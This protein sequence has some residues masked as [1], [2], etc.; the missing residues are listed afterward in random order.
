LNQVHTISK[1]EEKKSI[2]TTSSF[3]GLLPPPYPMSA[4]NSTP[5]LQT[6]YS[7]SR[8][9]SLLSSSSSSN[10]NANTYTTDSYSATRPNSGYGM[11]TSSTS[12]YTIPTQKNFYRSNPSPVA[13]P[14]NFLHKTREKEKSELSSLNDKFADYVEKVRY[15]EAQNKKVHL[16][17]SILSDKQQS[18]CQ[19]IK[20]MFET[21]LKELKQ[22]VEKIS[23]EKQNA[24]YVAKDIQQTIPQLKQKLSQTF[25]ESDSSKYDTEKVE[26]QLSGIE[27]DVNM[28]KRRLNHQDD[29]HLRWKQLAQHI[30]RLV[31]QAKNEIQNETI[32]KTKCEQQ[33]QQLKIDMK[34]LYEQQQQ[35]INDLKLTTFGNS[36]SSNTFSNSGSERA[37]FFKSELSN[38]IRKIR[39]EYER[40]NDLQRQDLHNQF[41]LQY[42]EISK[43][44]PDIQSIFQSEHD[45]ERVRQDED[46]VRSDV[47]RV[48]HDIMN[49][50]QKNSE[51]KIRLREVQIKIDMIQDERKRMDSKQNDEL[52][53][54][55]EKQDRMS[56]EFDDVTLKQTSLEKEINT[57][58]DLL[59]GTLK[60][61]VDQITDDYQQQGNSNQNG[62]GKQRGQR[63]ASMDRNGVTNQY[64]RGPWSSNMLYGNNTNKYEIAPT[65]VAPIATTITDNT[66]VMTN[67]LTTS[68]SMGDLAS[69]HLRTTEQSNSSVDSNE[70]SPNRTSSA[71]TTTTILHTR[72]N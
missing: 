11:T 32:I 55:R 22:A 17:S 69:R 15:L 42:T 33:K 18:S 64:Y 30:Q 4:L 3:L 57:Y 49:I 38:A 27:A 66:S 16:E 20:Q 68:K 12:S 9:P 29:E 10:I 24:Q 61:V 65:I 2:T 41:M 56:Q 72:R 8:M 37:Q 31:L 34:S 19:H 48:R 7:T 71:T 54:L 52:N 39:Q 5:L 45:Q 14:F 6:S 53:E 36:S 13:P 60:T 50:K 35:R 28:Y 44:Y 1:T 51:L 40:Q 59:E 46:K 62:L 21:E 47:Q 67:G 43:Q 26:K 58:R 23:S 70:S 25:K 63:S